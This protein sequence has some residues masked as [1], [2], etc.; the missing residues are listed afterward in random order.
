MRIHFS[1]E[2]FQKIYI[3]LSNLAIQADKPDILK[4]ENTGMG[5]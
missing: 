1:R 4:T 5:K 2:T 3:V